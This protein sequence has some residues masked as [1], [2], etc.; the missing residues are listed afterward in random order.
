MALLGRHKCERGCKPLPGAKGRYHDSSRQ[1]PY[2]D[3]YDPN[4]PGALDKE[5]NLVSKV[6]AAE[7]VP[8]RPESQPI[9]EPTPGHPRPAQQGGLTSSGRPAEIVP[10]AKTPIKPP[11]PQDYVVDALHTRAPINRCLLGL[12]QVFAWQDDWLEIAEHMPKDQFKLSE[13]ADDTIEMDPRNFYSRIVTRVCMTVGCK[14]QQQAHHAI[15]T[16]LFFGDW[17][18]FAVMVVKHEMKAWKESPRMARRKAENALKKKV[19]ADASARVVT[20]TSG[21]APPLATAVTA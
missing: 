8:K 11:E 20:S 9:A 12:W 18:A 13:N 14:T 10:R 2:A 21:L 19:V 15:D 17:G 1:C 3:E 4:Y 16:F 5:G 6:K 7:K